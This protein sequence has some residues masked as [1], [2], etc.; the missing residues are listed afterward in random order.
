MMERSNR[1]SHLAPQLSPS[2]KALLRGED[3]SSKG[4]AK[5]DPTPLSGEIPISA[6]PNGASSRM[7]P[8]YPER[9]SSASQIPS[10]TMNLPIRPAPPPQAP[11]PRAPRRTEASSAVEPRASDPRASEHT[12]QWRSGVKTTYPSSSENA[13]YHERF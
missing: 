4:S 1:R 11:L 9:T 5:K 6:A 7:R 12:Q 2:T 3:K 13:Q 8:S 10:S